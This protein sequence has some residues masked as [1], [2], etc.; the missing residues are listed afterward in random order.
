MNQFI[1]HMKI[2][3]ILRVC[4]VTRMPLA[5]LI[6][7]IQTEVGTTRSNS[8]ELTTIRSSGCEVVVHRLLQI[9]KEEGEGDPLVR[10]HDGGDNKLGGTN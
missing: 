1:P 3:D 8:T 6:C 2:H 9:A 4:L 7:F 5:W 10:G